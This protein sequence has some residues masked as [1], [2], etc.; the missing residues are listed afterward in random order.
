M[1]RFIPVLISILCCFMYFSP[2]TL[3]ASRE[4]LGYY[5]LAIFWFL[6]AWLAALGYLYIGIRDRK[7]GL[8][9]TWPYWISLAVIL[10]CYAIVLNAANHGKFVTI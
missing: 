4:S 7:S 3:N 10:A 9:V 1:F 5:L 8:T 2:W 6:G